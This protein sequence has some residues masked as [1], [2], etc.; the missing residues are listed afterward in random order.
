MPYALNLSYISEQLHI[1]VMFVYDLPAHKT[2]HVRTH[3]LVS[4]PFKLKTKENGCNVWNIE[5]KII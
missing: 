4:I 5:Y 2:V 3:W 1:T